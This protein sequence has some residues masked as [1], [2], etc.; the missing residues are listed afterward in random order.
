MALTL[1]VKCRTTKVF[2]RMQPS[3]RL[4]RLPAREAACRNRQWRMVNS[5]TSAVPSRGGSIATVQ[6]SI[7]PLK[8]TNFAT[9]FVPPSAMDALDWLTVLTG[10]AA[11]GLPL[12]HVISK[13][14]VTLHGAARRRKSVIAGLAIRQIG[15]SNRMIRWARPCPR[16]RGYFP[17]RTPFPIRRSGVEHHDSGHARVCLRDFSVSVHILEF[18]LQR[19]L[20]LDVFLRDDR[21]FGDNLNRGGARQARQIHLLPSVHPQIFR[22]NLGGRWLGVTSLVVTAAHKSGCRARCADNQY[23]Q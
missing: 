15:A 2:L 9:A 17:S 10:T 18:P 7:I 12:Q 5:G 1:G 16:L 23:R 8:A 4:G 13:I 22:D 19:R 20:L 6:A 11:Q 21:V 14:C 3:G